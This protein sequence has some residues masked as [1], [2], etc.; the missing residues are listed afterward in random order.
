[1][2]T[3][4]RFDTWATRALGFRGNL[5]SFNVRWPRSCSQN[6]GFLGVP[7]PQ[8]RVMDT[9][10][11]PEGTEL[12]GQAQRFERFFSW[13]ASA[14]KECKS[15]QHLLKHPPSFQRAA[16]SGGHTSTPCLCLSLV[17][18]HSFL[19]SFAHSHSVATA[20]EP[21]RQWA[22]LPVGQ[23]AALGHQVLGQPLRLGSNRRM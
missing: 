13:K 11:P 18:V 6:G 14:T 21:G 4:D 7:T 10:K 12:E 19:H 16:A 15:H 3:S 23:D 8:G 1:M 22:R 17:F 20:A 9:Q 2:R 5:C